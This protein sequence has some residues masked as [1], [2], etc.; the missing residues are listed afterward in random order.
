MTKEQALKKIKELEE[1]VKQEE[2]KESIIPGML[3]YFWNYDKSNRII[4]H[5]VHTRD[6]GSKKQYYCE[7]NSWF[8][9][10]EPAWDIVWTLLDPPD[11]AEYCAMDEYGEWYWYEKDPQVINNVWVSEKYINDKFSFK[12]HPNWKESKMKRPDGV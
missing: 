3:Y 2:Q 6:E 11:W 7:N 8:R 5:V 4:G 1:Y 10:A 12:K 9:H